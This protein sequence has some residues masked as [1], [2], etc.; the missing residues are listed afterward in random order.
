[1]LDHQF[2]KAFGV[3]VIGQA[4][5]FRD[6]VVSA[7]YV[8]RPQAGLRDKS[9]ELFDCQRFVVIIYLLIIDA[10][11]TKQL[12]QIAARR[13]GWF[14]VNDYFVCHILVPKPARK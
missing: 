4:E 2:D 5:L 9:A 11:F 3:G 6:G 12:C 1:M 8:P 10:V 13:S 7:K 14:F